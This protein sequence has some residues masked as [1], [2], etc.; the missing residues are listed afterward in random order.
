MRPAEHIACKQLSVWIE[1]PL[2]A[3]KPESVAIMPLCSATMTA[4]S[5]V[6]VSGEQYTLS[7]A[8]LPR[9]A[10]WAL[11]SALRKWSHCASVTASDVDVCMLLIGRKTHLAC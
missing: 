1:R 3:W 7:C 8:E 4:V 10:S 2:H 9:S 11:S 5:S 6:L